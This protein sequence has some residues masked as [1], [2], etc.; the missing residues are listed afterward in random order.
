MIQIMVHHLSG[1]TEMVGELIS[2]ITVVPDF[3]HTRSQILLLFIYLHHS[4]LL[5]GSLQKSWNNPLFVERKITQ[6]ERAPLTSL[7]LS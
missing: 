1:K 3:E 4:A 7:L 5:T 2:P 6:Q